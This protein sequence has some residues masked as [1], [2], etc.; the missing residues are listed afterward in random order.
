MKKNNGG[1]TW[2]AGV[3]TFAAYY[4]GAKLGFALTFQP[5]PV[6][7]LWPP[8]A[9]L[10]A[11]L[12]LTATR[13]W[14]AIILAAFAAHLAIELQSGV[15]ILMVLC[16]FLSNSAQALIAAACMIRFSR[17]PLRFDNLR[18]TEVFVLYGVLGAPFLISFVDV[19]FVKLVGWGKSDYWEMWRIRFFSNLVAALTFVP[20]VVLGVLGIRDGLKMPSGRRIMEGA[21]VFAGLIIL[22][23]WVFS[24][25]NLL[26]SQVPVL[27]CAPLPLL[28]WAA[29]RFGP[30]GLSISLLI[31]AL[32][33]IWGS[34]HHRGP[35]TQL[36]PIENVFSL[37]LFLIMVCV[38]L[39]F[40][41]ALLQE[42]RR[43]ESSLRASHMQISSLAG[44]LIHAQEEER[45]R[46]ARELHDDFSQRLAA[47]SLALNHIT[48]QISPANADVSRQLLAIK[49][50]TSELSEDLR[51]L[52]HDLHP[53][54]LEHAGLPVALQSLAAEFARG[55]KMRVDLHLEA[56]TPPVPINI[57]LCCFRV[58]QE[59]LRNAARHAQATLAQVSVHVTDSRV[60]LS[61]ADNGLGIEMEKLCSSPGLGITSMRERVK[62][63]G[64]EFEIMRREKV[65]TL[66]AVTVPMGQNALTESEAPEPIADIGNGELV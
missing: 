53:A 63:L 48:R 14:W 44:R 6:S 60:F 29:V 16:W 15:P 19:G 56:G 40:L 2:V 17:Q 38:P 52:S 18:N 3:A 28:L 34:V 50:R 39:M 13:N 10:L 32:F 62:L 43:T 59:A 25:E 33:I 30:G 20:A 27:V 49:E 55:R 26:P 37:Q 42:Q 51:L 65:G 11:I 1:G 54:T 8:N 36:N 21:A 9:L 22:G 4:A 46:I 23:V 31:T 66:V 7:T 45:K 35:F 47:Q 41:A 5:N 12:L 64:G 57:A 58:V 24:G 61:V